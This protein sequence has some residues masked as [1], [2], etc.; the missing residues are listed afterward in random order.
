[1]SKRRRPAPKTQD[2][3]P[4]RDGFANFTARMGMG[5]DNVF[6]A[7]GY[8]QNLI[9]RNRV[10]LE[11]IY[12]GSWIGGK[13]IDDYADDMTRAGIDIDSPDDPEAVKK[14]QRE[15]S[16]LAI[17]QSLADGIRWG[18]LYGGAIA[19]LQIDGQ[20]TAQPLRIDTV[21]KGAFKGLAVFDRWQLEPDLTRVIQSGPQIGLPEYYR[22]VTGWS[23][24]A[25][26]AHSKPIHHTRIIRFCG[27]TLPYWQAQQEQFWGESVIERLY[28][29]LVGYDTATL[30]TANLIQRAHLRQV[31]VKNLRDI[32]AAGGKAEENLIR[33]FDYIRQLQTSE[34]LTLLDAD[35]EMTYNSYTFS[36][37]PDVL[38]Q[39][40]QQVSGACGIPLVRLFGQSP[41]GMSATGES[42]IR[43]YYDTIKS[44]QE[45][46]LREGVDR[47]LSVMYQSLFSQS[48]PDTLD[49]DF[50]PLWQLSYT[51][52]ATIAK[53]G[54]EAISVAMDSGIIDTPTAARELAQLADVT[55]MF[56]NI[57]PEYIAELESEPPMPAEGEP[58]GEVPAA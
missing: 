51:E 55:G 32:L 31:G 24:N 17:W 21:G 52:K 29:R 39:F 47:I 4:T 53:T 19:V 37:L 26:A 30:G 20:D 42:D 22:I 35:D 13:V 5:A 50:T 57:T 48:R 25:A 18:R 40:G 38:I 14:L 34:G 45:A 16:R 56:T 58:D 28:D 8:T 1:M 49:F 3:Q 12:R 33:Q 11:N 7:G 9:T 43:N 2:A 36:G 41:A 27:I 44:R 10:V 15:F 46:D 54:A 23:G 6:S